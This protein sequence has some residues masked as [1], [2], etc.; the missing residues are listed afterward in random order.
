MY[1]WSESV[2]VLY[3]SFVNVKL[4]A[5]ISFDSVPCEL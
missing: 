1:E 5:L 4:N 3:D 2:C